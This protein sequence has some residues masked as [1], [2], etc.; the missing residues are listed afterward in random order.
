MKST[1][2]TRKN[3]A[4]IWENENVEKLTSLKTEKAVLHEYRKILHNT[5]PIKL[6]EAF[7]TFKS[8]IRRNAS[9]NY[10]SRLESM[11][12]DF[13]GFLKV[14][15]PLIKKLNEIDVNIAESYYQQIIQSGRF[16]NEISYLRGKKEITAPINN[17]NLSNNTIN[18]FL[19]FL[20]QFFTKLLGDKDTE[21][22]VSPFRKIKKLPKEAVSREIFTPEQLAI[23]GTESEKNESF[24]YPIFLVSVNTGLREGDACT[25]E[26][27]EIDFQ[28][29]WINR[30]LN[31]TRRTTGK[32]VRI[33]ILEPLWEFLK[34][35]SQNNSKYLLPDQAH[36]YLSNSSGISY[37]VKKFLNNKK[38]GIETTKK[39]VG[40]DQ[41]V[42][43]RDFHSLR[44]SFCYIAGEAGVPFPIVKDIMGHMT[45]R[46][47]QLY[48]DHA[49][50][51]D[52]KKHL[53]KIPNY[54]N[55]NLPNKSQK[56]ES[57]KILEI[58][59][60]LKTNQSDRLAQQ[61]ETILSS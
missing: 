34:N 47:T 37:R 26:W 44:H 45:E 33:P 24:L 58:Q 29:R 49:S 6:E 7:Q 16:L 56:S 14:K 51:G 60:L 53:L 21:I 27:E 25:L 15:H 17:K 2:E 9:E 40:R 59:E 35:I 30:M 3:E 55:P 19:V 23:I 10:I 61:I 57:D 54:L 39:I 41:V 52:K 48:M 50:D 32:T 31:K 46:M 18:D 28:R 36:M 20:N 38:L 8:Q 12:N 1:G 22:P 43:I 5:D 4:E 13:Y 11:W 42:S